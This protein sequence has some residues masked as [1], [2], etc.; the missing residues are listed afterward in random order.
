MGNSRRTMMAIFV[1]NLDDFELQP[2]GPTVTE[3]G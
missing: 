2:R 3:L 1:T